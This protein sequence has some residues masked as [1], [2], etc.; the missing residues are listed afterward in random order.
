[1]DDTS[2][3]NKYW[4]FELELARIADSLHV[5]RRNLIEQPYMFSIEIRQQ[6]VLLLQ[7]QIDLLKKGHELKRHQQVSQNVIDLSSYRQL[8]R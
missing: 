4:S 1:M 3:V 5:S 6:V 2:I 7:K 8:L